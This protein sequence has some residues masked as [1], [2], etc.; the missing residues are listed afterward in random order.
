MSSYD[1]LDAIKG[2]NRTR[3]VIATATLKYILTYST[4]TNVGSSS[5]FLP[6]SAL[7]E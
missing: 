4:E 6:P 3:K 7:W 2:P 5:F 1:W